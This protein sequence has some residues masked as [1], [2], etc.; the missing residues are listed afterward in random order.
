MEVLQFAAPS[1]SFLTGEQLVLLA[2]GW[3]LKTSAFVLS[4]YSTDLQIHRKEMGL[5][6]TSSSLELYLSGCKWS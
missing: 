4:L 1:F 3:S 5:Q 6:V 2:H